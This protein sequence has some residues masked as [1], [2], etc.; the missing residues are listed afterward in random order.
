MATAELSGPQSLRVEMCP[1]QASTGLTTLAVNVIVMA[2]DVSPEKPAGECAY[3]LS[4]VV[5]PPYSLKLPAI[6]ATPEPVT[7]GSGGMAYVVNAP[8][9]F[10]PRHGF[11]VMT[12]W[13]TLVK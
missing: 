10:T 8:Q 11:A 2:A 3:E 1:P 5:V 7:C 9:P 6:C 4:P 12:D 13:L